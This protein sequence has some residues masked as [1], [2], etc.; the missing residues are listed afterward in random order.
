LLQK[1]L[2]SL[3]TALHLFC[4]F[5]VEGLNRIPKLEKCCLRPL[6]FDIKGSLQGL[7]FFEV[8]GLPACAQP[9]AEIV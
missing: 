6:S 3:L 4:I 1:T 2:P 5:N 9:V 7:R 8:P